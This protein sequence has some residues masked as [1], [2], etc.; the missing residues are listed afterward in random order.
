MFLEKILR[1][2][3][4]VCMGYRSVFSFA[5]LAFAFASIT[6]AYSQT[7]VSQVERGR[8]LATVGN[9]IS[10][11]TMNGNAEF[12][13]GVLFDTP[14][15]SIYST[16]ITSDPEVGIGSWTKKQFIRSMRKGVRADGANLYPAFPFPSFTIITDE[17]LDALWAYLQTIPASKA[18]PPKSKLKFPYNQR[19]LMGSWKML[20]FKKGPYK[21]DTS[22]SRD[23]NRGAYLVKGLAHCG[24]CHTP[25]NS[26]GAE[27][28]KR[29]LAG[30]NYLDKINEE[31][32][33]RTWHA[34]NLTSAPSGLAAWS[35]EDIQSYL[36]TGHSSRAGVFG[37]M[38][39]VIENSTQHFSEEDALAVAT[40]LKD[41]P[42]IEQKSAA[43]KPEQVQAGQY[44]YDI[45]C[46]TCH[47]PT[48]RGAS[49]TGPPLVGSPIVNAEDPS[50]LINV[51]IYGAHVPYRL[52][53]PDKWKSMD[54][55]GD[56]LD[57]EEIAN[58]S[59]FIRGSW[60]NS[61]PPVTEADVEKQR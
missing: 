4:P 23:W 42:P 41:L 32:E 53:G 57:D 15:G 26:F 43:P 13:G 51:I 9:C 30:A 47:L 1:V 17:D 27:K 48:G 22:K 29:F 52:A 39:E 46:G 7:D 34:I 50:S 44:L 12:S 54:P 36:L 55:L 18:E 56:K 59:N 45:H 6:S 14:F 49:D 40:Y 11:H 24:A 61:A 28:K 2:R 58:I 19:W 21:E 3:T 20:F 33:F 16:N 10:C 38:N 60:G 37:P 5:L 31:D 35:A 8:Y 25:R